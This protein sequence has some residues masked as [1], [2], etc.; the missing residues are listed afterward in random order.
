MVPKPKLTQLWQSVSLVLFTT[1]YNV[2]KTLFTEYCELTL[3]AALT[4]R[5]IRHADSQSLNTHKALLISC[6]HDEL[7]M[8][9][10]ALDSYLEEV[11]IGSKGTVAANKL[12]EK[13]RTV[14][15]KL[16]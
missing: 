15:Q 16:K 13:L 12:V 2:I 14:T 7:L 6:R 11:G 5:L 3:V 10:Q 4:I 9:L 1:Y 8:L